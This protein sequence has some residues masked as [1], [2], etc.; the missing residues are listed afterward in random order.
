MADFERP[1]LTLEELDDST[2]NQQIVVRLFW[3][4]EAR[5]PRR[6]NQLMSLDLLLLDEKVRL[7]FL[8][9]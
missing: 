4:W 3:S 5:N 1:Y 7:I 6:G 8:L 2:V 9:F